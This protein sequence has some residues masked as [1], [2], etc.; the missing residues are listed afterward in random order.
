MAKQINTV[1][2]KFHRGQQ[3]CQISEANKLLRAL[4]TLL[5]GASNFLKEKKPPSSQIYFAVQTGILPPHIN[6]HPKES[7]ENSVRAPSSDNAL[8]EL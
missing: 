6:R 1:V 4:R 8:D 2:R 5:M 7:F 3:N